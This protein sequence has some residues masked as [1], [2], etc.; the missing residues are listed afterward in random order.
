MSSRHALL[1][2][3]RAFDVATGDLSF[4]PGPE[5]PPDEFSI[6]YRPY[7]LIVQTDL[8]SC[9]KWNSTVPSCCMDNSRERREYEIELFDSIAK[10]DRRTQMSRALIT[11]MGLLALVCSASA[12]RPS[13]DEDRRIAQ[14]HH[15]IYDDLDKAVNAAGKAGKPLMAVIRCPL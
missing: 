11:G 1:V 12:R 9:R 7:T 15:W 14:A 5:G 13:L 6:G 2:Q 4:L 10:C 3:A 8:I